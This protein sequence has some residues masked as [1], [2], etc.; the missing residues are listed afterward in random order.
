MIVTEV[1]RCLHVFCVSEHQSSLLQTSAAGWGEVLVKEAAEKV[2]T[3]QD[4]VKKAWTSW[5]HSDLRLQ[6]PHLQRTIQ[7]KSWL[8]WQDV[9]KSMRNMPQTDPNR[10]PK[11]VS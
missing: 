9:V 6:H 11:T 7:P 5:F 8:N 1:P 10:P 3:V 4:T 2:Q